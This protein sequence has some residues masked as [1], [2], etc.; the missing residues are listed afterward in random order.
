MDRIEAAKALFFQGLEH[1]QQDRLAEAEADFR[2]CLEIIPDRPSTLT[3]LAAV[4]LRRGKAEEAAELSRRVV[5][6]DAAAVQGWLY[7]GLAEKQL[8]RTAQAEES[9]RRALALAPDQLEAGGALGG[10]LHARGRHAEA[11]AVYERMLAIAPDHAGLWCDKAGALL[12]LRRFGE[13]RAAAEKALQYAPDIAGAWGN[14]GSALHELKLHNEALAAYDQAEKIAGETP[15]VWSCRG[16]TYYGLGRLQEAEQA[17]RSALALDAAYAPAWS[18]LGNVLGALCQFAEAAEAYEQAVRLD[19]AYSTARWNLSITQLALG[20]FA[21]GW[22]NY[23]AR[24]L[25][26]DADE[27]RHVTM[28]P[29]RR[30]ED[31]VGRSVLVWCEQGMGDAMQFCRYIPMLAARGIK[32]FFEVP[33]TLQ[34]LMQSLEGCELLRQDRDLPRGDFQCAL[35]SLPGLFAT[36]ADSIPAN[37][38]Y[39]HVRQELVVAWGER[40]RRRPAGLHIGVAC[41]GNPGL[42]N[43]ANRSMPLAALEPL[44]ACG[45]VFLI[46]KEVRE[47]DRAFL[48]AHSELSFLGPQIEDFA[49]SGA[50]AEN[51]DV[52]LSVDTSLA[53]L[54]GA[55]GRPLHVLLPWSPEWRWQLE[56]KDSP[57][58]PQAMLHRQSRAGDWDGVMASVIRALQTS[59]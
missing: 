1:F 43:D 35:M 52:I 21:A 3:N 18:N 12:A 24:W 42:K 58:Y 40:L 45:Q 56:R 22:A 5:A 38:P 8:H 53:H 36:G 27:P 9:L 32:V 34:D 13:A 10:V 19:P 49:D 50:I 54:A 31:A 30:I 39:L 48:S 37:L 29:L 16:N 59:A 7:L 20:N 2:A 17:C 14:L 44:L 47:R 46:Q 25:R 33:A 4:L 26:S 23:E 15:Q 55:L 11:L 41:T 28:P 57:W 6:Q 51:M